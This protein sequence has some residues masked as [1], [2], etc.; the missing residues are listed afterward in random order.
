MIQPIAKRI[1]VE[2]VFKEKK[3]GLIFLKDDLPFAYKVIAVGDEVTKV[4][5][6]D[7]IIIQYA[8]DIKYEDIS[9]KIV[10]EDNVIAKI[11]AV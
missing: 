4:A 2:P 7:I 11:T 1:A 10:T 5:L 6:N 8:T 9:Y 3:S